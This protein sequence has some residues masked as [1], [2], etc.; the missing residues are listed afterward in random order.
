MTLIKK[1]LFTA[2]FVFAVLVVPAVLL[3]L[4]VDAAQSFSVYVIVYGTIIFAILGYIVASIRSMEIKFNQTMEE[5]KKQNAAIAYKLTNNSNIDA[6]PMITVVNEHP[7]PEPPFVDSQKVTLNPAEP[8]VMPDA[9]TSASVT[10]ASKKNV[11]DNFD[12]FK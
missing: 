10:G 2:V 6:A 4:L 1:L 5:I 3:L 7:Q 9:K 11:D 8:L 12:D